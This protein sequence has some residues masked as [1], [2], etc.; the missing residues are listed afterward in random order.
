VRALRDALLTPVGS[1][2]GDAGATTD[3]LVS[4]ARV[5]AAARSSPGLV[6]CTDGP[7][8]VA[9]RDE[10]PSTAS[11]ERWRA[12][13]SGLGRVVVGV[14]GSARE[15]AAV[16]SAVAALP[17]WPAVSSPHASA[18]APSPAD[19]VAALRVYEASGSVGPGAA[20]VVVA[21]HTASPLVATLAARALTGA[22]APLVRR[23][24]A[25]APGTLVEEVTATAHADG[26]CLRVELGVARPDPHAAEPLAPTVAA[27]LAVA[28]QELLEAVAGVR[29]SSVAARSATHT[30]YA[31]ADPREAAELAAWWTAVG[32]SGVT[33][34]TR[35]VG[36][37][38]SFVGLGP[39][40]DEAADPA[41]RAAAVERAVARVAASWES[42]VVEARAAVERGQ[43]TVSVLLASPCGT[44]GEGDAD[45]GLGALAV[46]ALVEAWR[47]SPHDRDVDV[48]EWTTAGGL[49]L[50][51]TATRRDDEPPADTALRA[52]NTAGSAFAS[53]PPDGTAIARARAALST[54]LA[55]D[56]ARGFAALAEA[57][58]P[59]H[60]SWVFPFV[61]GR[62]LDGWSDG[63]VSARLAAL[64]RGP[65]RVAVLASDDAAQG[66][67]AARAVDRWVPR[68]SD[69]PRACPARSSATSPRPGTYAVT[70]A[71]TTTAWL[72]APLLG[73]SGPL[74]A[75]EAGDAIAA[76]L[77]GPDGLLARALSSGL[78]SS[79]GARVVGP[80]DTPQLVVRVETR[81]GALD[82]AVAQVR[83]LF[84]RL[85]RGALTDSDR[86]RALRRRDDE[87]LALS[88][89]R[90]GRLVR[91]WRGADPA[92][93]AASAPSSAPPLDT[94]QAVLAQSLHDDAL[95]IVAAR[96]A[97]PPPR[98]TP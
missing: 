78:A 43:G 39:A 16:T 24:R 42:P 38:A 35:R 48:T 91:L 77:D 18:P 8:A 32:A 13:A 53:S 93:S 54:Q 44:A 89:T 69:L 79:W 85:R 12:A 28:R 94:L 17:E 49:G 88:L 86:T 40:V 58:S 21:A 3:A 63:A 80:D 83:G 51:V 87:A 45:A 71:S 61:G 92:A 1:A 27:A 84:D 36:A 47:S 73:A 37:D 5:A 67:L 33:G 62:S 2:A 20:R 90:R 4:L 66:A 75:R 11:L 25:V 98:P 64:R 7:A 22:D 34:A 57:V 41:A 29:E 96:P 26:G 46:S 56:D 15:A 74:A 68:G 60:P 59:G 50:L 81:P 9:P 31:A 76:A 72:A 97:P 10:A 95:V 19:P 6:R 14:A 70:A 52:A 23:L 65:L 30:A 82:A 55:T